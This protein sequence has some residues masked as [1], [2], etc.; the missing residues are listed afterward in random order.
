MEET[1]Q[2][3]PAVAEAV[4]VGV[5]PSPGADIRLKAFVVRER[6]VAGEELIRYLRERL[7]VHKVPTLIEFRDALPRSSAGKVLRGRLSEE[8]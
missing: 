6:E 1:L 4:V 5:R 7:S 3:H 8:A 2:L